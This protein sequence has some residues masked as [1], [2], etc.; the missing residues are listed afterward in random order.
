MGPAPGSSSPRLMVPPMELSR[1]PPCAPHA[2]SPR[3]LKLCAPM[4]MPPGSLTGGS[5]KRGEPGAHRTSGWNCTSVSLSGSSTAAALLLVML[6]VQL[7]GNG[8]VPTTLLAFLRQ[9]WSFP[10][11][12]SGPHQPWSTNLR[13]SAA[14][15]RASDRPSER[16]S[17]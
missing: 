12:G 4:P 14:V 6:T 8:R 11:S 9:Q 5:E 10:H 3:M 2:P 16:V 15:D 7:N 17:E 13:Q 1:L